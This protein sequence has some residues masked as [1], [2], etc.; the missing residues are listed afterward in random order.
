MAPRPREWI[1]SVLRKIQAV[2]IAFLK[3]LLVLRVG[4]EA[5]TPASTKGAIAAEDKNKPTVKSEPEDVCSAME[6]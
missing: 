5:T 1:R 6:E 4:V 3:E 2:I